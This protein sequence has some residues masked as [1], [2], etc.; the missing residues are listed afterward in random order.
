MPKHVLDPSKAK[1][2][3]LVFLG[4]S[5]AQNHY[6]GLS[7]GK[8]GK[9]NSDKENKKAGDQIGHPD[10]YTHQTAFDMNLVLD[11]E[12]KFVKSTDDIGW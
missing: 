1:Q 8:D 4:L 10:S 12:H 7:E 5:L 3:G 9:E 2:D 6:Y 11:R